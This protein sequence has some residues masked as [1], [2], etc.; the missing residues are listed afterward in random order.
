M[1]MGADQCAAKIGIWRLMT[2]C[3]TLYEN[4]VMHIQRHSAR[5]GRL[6]CY[7]QLSAAVLRRKGNDGV[8]RVI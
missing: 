5:T 2:S 7:S 1:A 3:M 4:S 8:V 6:Q